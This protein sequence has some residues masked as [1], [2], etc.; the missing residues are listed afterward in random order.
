[1]TEQYYIWQRQALQGGTVINGTPQ[2]YYESTGPGKLLHG[3]SDA[4]G[5][6]NYTSYVLD[7]KSIL[8]FRS[9][10]LADF[11][12]QRTGI[13]GAYFEHTL[14][15]TRHL[16]SWAILRPEVRFDYTSGQKGYDNGT[17]RDQFTFNMDLILRF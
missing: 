16:T 2:P 14:G 5:I 8:V 12:G 10:C 9:D 15:Y 1:M 11:Q 17:K 3:L 7:E 4:Y 13:P 6:V